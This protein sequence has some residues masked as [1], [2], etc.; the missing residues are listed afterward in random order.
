MNQ[1]VKWILIICLSL[2]V[3][4]ACGLVGSFTLLRAGG[5]VLAN[6]I[7][8]DAETVTEI[9]GSIAEYDLPV[10]FGKPY[11]VQ[12]GGFSMI[13]HT[14]LDN[15]SH[16]YFF[17]TPGNVHFDQGEIE[18]KFSPPGG[19]KFTERYVK[20]D[21]QPGMIGDQETTFVVSEGLNGEGNGY[22]Q[23]SAPFTSSDGGNAVVVIS[24]PVASWDQDVVDAFLGSIR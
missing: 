20:M 12:L 16:I 3:L 7:E 22:R 9:K 6:S 2:F 5:S 1:T 8:T 23:I 15:H 10:G 13:S 11:A 21:E 18:R 17:R 24:M 14:G 19:M 4:C